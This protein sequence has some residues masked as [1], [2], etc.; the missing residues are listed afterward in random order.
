MI[1]TVLEVDENFIFAQAFIFFLA[2][3]ETPGNVIAC[4][5]YEIAKNQTV[6]ET[7][8]AEIREVVKNH[9]GEISFEALQ[10][11][12][13]LRQVISGQSRVDAN[14]KSRQ[15]IIR[16]N[17]ETRV[18]ITDILMREACIKTFSLTFRYT[19]KLFNT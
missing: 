1:L 19:K 4:A 13:Y 3:F 6:Q 5:L 11:M 2:G 16:N 12:K 15:S 9:K 18:W 14:S 8:V 7:L 10:S 17:W